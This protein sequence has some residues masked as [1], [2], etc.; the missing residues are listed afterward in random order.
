MVERAH[1]WQPEIMSLDELAPLAEV[2]S[3]LCG[4]VGLIF[5]GI[6]LRQQRDARTSSPA[7]APQPAPQPTPSE[8]AD[9]DLGPHLDIPARSEWVPSSGH[10]P[11]PPPTVSAPG[12]GQAGVA[13]YAESPKP[14]RRLGLL[15]AGLAL[16]AVA[17][18]A[19][20]FALVL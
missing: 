7:A 15:V 14:R 10:L 4:L 5:T 16:L 12:S 6:G 13:G 8:Q 11:S 19:L 2:T 18:A 3:A 17:G 9:R 1:V 20:V